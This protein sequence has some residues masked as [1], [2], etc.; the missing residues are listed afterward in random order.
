MKKQGF[1]LAE[2]LLCVGIIGIVGAIGAVATKH[3]IEQSYKGYWYTG[4]SALND[5]IADFE[6]NK[7]FDSDDAN[8]R[9][10][11]AAEFATRL[12]NIVIGRIEGNT[13]VIAPNGIRYAISYNNTNNVYTVLMTVPQAK[14]RQNQ[15]GTATTELVYNHSTKAL[16]PTSKATDGLV[17]IQ[18]RPDLLAFYLNDGT[19]TNTK[20]YYSYRDAYCRSSYN[21][22]FQIKQPQDFLLKSIMAINLH[23]ENDV[24]FYK[25]DLKPKD[26]VPIY[27]DDWKLK[28]DVPFYKDDWK[29]KNTTEEKGEKTGNGNNNTEYVDCNGIPKGIGSMVLVNPRKIK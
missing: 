22:A 12:N 2:L 27:K 23:H 4:Y 6:Y 10:T 5:S 24:P 9:I 7:R 11:T 16:I 28:D 15:T 25:D 20:R 14:T 3:S 19:R 13:T 1:T 29:P 26:D 21:I 18:N 17:S 8:E